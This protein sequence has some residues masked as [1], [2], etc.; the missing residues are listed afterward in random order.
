MPQ[1]QR[2]HQGSFSI[3]KKKRRERE[4][5]KTHSIPIQVQLEAI[6]LDMLTALEIPLNQA[7][8]CVSESFHWLESA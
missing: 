8:W 3:Q 6:T 1:V 4:K 2:Q 5:K 7:C